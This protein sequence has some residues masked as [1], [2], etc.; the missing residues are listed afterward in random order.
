[1]TKIRV[2]LENLDKNTLKKDN[3]DLKTLRTSKTELK[4]NLII[5]KTK[6]QYKIKDN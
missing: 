6:I 4:K 1:V 2:E 5:K 3:K